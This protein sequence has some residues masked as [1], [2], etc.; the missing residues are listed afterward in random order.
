MDH[1]LSGSKAV[2]TGIVSRQDHVWNCCLVTG[3]AVGS[4]LTMVKAWRLFN[5]R[6]K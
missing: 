3:R 4:K 6:V 2:E 1:M 5:G